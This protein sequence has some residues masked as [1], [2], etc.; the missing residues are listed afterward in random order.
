MICNVAAVEQM[1]WLEHYSEFSVLTR[2]MT[3]INDTI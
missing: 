2:G 1:E 3:M